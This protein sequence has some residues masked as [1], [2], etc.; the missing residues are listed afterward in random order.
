M[1]KAGKLIC[2]LMGLTI[3]AGCG[4]SSD[5]KTDASL[6]DLLDEKV[7]VVEDKKDDEPLEEPDD[8]EKGDDTEEETVSEGEKEDGTDYE[9]LYAPVLSEV[10]T[11]AKAG[12][13]YDTEYSYISNG[14]MEKVMYPSDE[15]PLEDI[16]YIIED[17]SGDG[18]PELLIGSNDEYS[19]SGE[20]SYIYNIFSIREDEP[21]H[22]MDGW[23][24]SS[25]CPMENGHFYYFGSGGAAVTLIGENHLSEDGSEIVWDDFFFTDEKNDGTIGTYH[26]K[27]GIFDV[28]E[29]KE[30]DISDEQFAKIMDEYDKRCIVLSWTPIGSFKGS[31][32]TDGTIADKNTGLTNRDVAE[33]ADNLGGLVCALEC[34]DFDGDGSREAFVVT[35]NN[36]DMGGYIP[37]AVWFIASDQTTTKF[38]PD[39]KGLSMY[40]SEKHYM[41]YAAENKGFFYGDCGGYGSG[42]LTFVYGVKDGKPY[43]LE[44]SMNI[45]GFYQDEPGVFFTT[46][47]DFTEYHKY[48]ITELNY[49]KKT[50]EFSKGKVTD[51]DYMEY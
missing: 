13:D 28:N 47:D 1:K 40:E 20:R 33:I 50:Q 11:V 15:D 19:D 49:D 45:Q 5:K 25:Y 51:K 14:I 37:D 26:N 8:K 30:I 42:W 23:A 18:V 43:E 44:I 12:Y 48:L 38:K 4:G 2:I 17:L 21:V 41:E 39:F 7:P 10:L 6:A 22:V 36:D 31:E 24:R 32:G 34:R 9:A 16:G 35:G 3:L 27:T 46:T 29:A